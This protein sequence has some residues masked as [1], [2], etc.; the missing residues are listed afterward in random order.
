[1]KNRIFRLFGVILCICMILTMLPISASANSDSV[2][3]MSLFSYTAHPFDTGH[4]WLYFENLT[5]A[6]ITVGVYTL[7][8]G[9]AV[10]VG[11]FKNTRSDGAGVYYNVE[12]YCTA[13]YGSNGRISLSME[14]NS[15][16]LN[17]VNGVINGNNLWTLV[18]N[19]SW[20]AAKVWNSVSSIDVFSGSTPSCL[21]TSMKVE[22][23]YK[24]TTNQPMFAPSAGEVYKQVDG[25]LK[26]VS[27]DSLKNPL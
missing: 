8:P 16:Q 25:G 20:F 5:D 4:S 22:S 17:T 14:I 10:S 24:T 2:C 21:K 6:P 18:R 7:A 11:T 23:C 3:R 9:K 15:D 19:C 12:A 26:V 13:N 27:S 1:M